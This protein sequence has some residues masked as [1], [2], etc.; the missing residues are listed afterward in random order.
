M[1]YPKNCPACGVYYRGLGERGQEEHTTLAAVDG[2]T[3][4]P[5][6][7]HRPGRVLELGCGGCGASFEWDYFGRSLSGDHLGV[8]RRLVRLPVPA[9]EAAEPADSGWEALSPR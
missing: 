9:A 6:Q 5:W 2:G 3:P 7:P 4:S 1:A 8:L